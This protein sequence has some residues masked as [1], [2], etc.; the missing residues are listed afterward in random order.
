MTETRFSDDAPLADA[1]LA[2]APL[3]DAPLIVI[4][5]RLQATRLPN[6]PLADIHGKPMIVHVWQ[7]AIAAGIGPVVVAASDDSIAEVIRAVGGVAI[8]T[9]PALPSG[10]DRVW[11]AV[12]E[13]DPLGTH[14]IIV[15][16]QGDMPTLEPQ[17]LHELVDGLRQSEADIGTLGVLSRDPRQ[18]DQS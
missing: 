10:S 13:F 15:N 18:C 6:K 4:P 17:L 16:L 12:Q 1:P 5:A 2:D 9:D 3:A 8:L 11:A 14:R 7:R